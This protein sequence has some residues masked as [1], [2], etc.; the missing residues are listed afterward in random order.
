ML[1]RTNFN[2]DDDELLKLMSSDSLKRNQDIAS[3]LR[4]LMRIDKG[5]SIFLDGKWGSGKTYYV[6]SLKIVIDELNACQGTLPTGIDTIA[7]MAFEGE[8]SWHCNYLPIY[9][10][11]W[12]YDY[13]SDPLASIACTLAAE[14]D[15]ARLG[16]GPSDSKVIRTAL[17]ALLEQILNHSIPGIGSAIDKTVQAMGAE[18]LLD[19]F[20]KRS[21]LRNAVAEAVNLVLKER[22]DKLL[23]IVDELDRCEPKFACRLLEELKTLFDL[24]NVVVLYSLNAKQLACVIEGQYGAGFNGNRYLSKFY[25]IAFPIRTVNMNDYLS[26]MEMNPNYQSSL[27]IKSIVEAHEMSLREASRLIE[28]CKPNLECLD[29]TRI[30]NETVF[31]V[32][33]MD[34]VEA[35]IRVSDPTAYD[36]LVNNGDY[37][38]FTKEVK[39][40]KGIKDCFVT[41]FGHCIKPD[42][43]RNMIDDQN[44]VDELIDAVAV[45]RWSNQFDKK[46]RAYKAINEIENGC[47]IP[48]IE[49]EN[50][51][52]SLY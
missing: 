39:C 44:R 33:F 36:R 22:A 52:S 37:S 18:D 31:R 34:I 9:Y 42:D 15:E 45:L 2:P 6:R 29:D 46:N 35:G 12:S 38:V 23:L 25:D 26:H 19:A 40:S 49:R 32:S 20:K 13:W 28:I 41:T 8:T 11:A 3:M 14:A 43:Y 48:V 27:V 24:D 47:L 1:Q 50:P 17:K 7:N 16:N 5:L 4:L 21:G 51:V 30:T 10:N